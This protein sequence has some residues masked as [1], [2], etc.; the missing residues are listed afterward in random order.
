M[1][2]AAVDVGT[3]TVRLIVREG[4]ETIERDTRITR[5]G[6]GVDAK[7]ELGAEPMRRTLE[8]IEEFV[9]R[10]RATGAERI[11]IAGTSAV[12]DAKNRS[13]FAERVLTDCAVPLEVLDGREEGRLAYTGATSWLGDGPYV[14]CDIGG[15]STELINPTEAISVDL[16]SVRVRERYLRGDPPSAASVSDARS[17]VRGV[18]AGRGVADGVGDGE[19]VG[20]AGTITTIA[21]L[22]AGLSAYDS[23]VVHAYRLSADGVRHWANE[24][25]E[26]S[27]EEI[28]GLGPVAPGRADVIGAGAIVLDAVVEVL[29]RDHVLVSERDILDGLVADLV[30]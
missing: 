30:G 12:R 19:L 24:L 25:N 14:V 6:E 1:R 3:N 17:A 18:F 11:R 23:D 15:G 28:R 16:G 21:A 4:D 2:V 10:A 7:G 8:T 29:R 27:A 20:V 26:M 9:T 5:L 13:E 22:D